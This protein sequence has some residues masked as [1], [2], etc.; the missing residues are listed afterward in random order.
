M[1]VC[2]AM[3]AVIC[4]GQI[5]G[6]T[7]LLIVIMALFL[8]VIALA[9]YFRLAFA[10]L[11]FFLPWSPL[12]KVGL[13]QISF[14]TIA[15]LSACL[16]Y[17]FMQG[18]SLRIFQIVLPAVIISLTLI[19]KALQSN[20]IANNYLCFAA[21]LVFFPCLTRDDSGSIDFWTLTVF[22]SVGIITA[23]FTAQQVVVYSNIAKYITVESYLK[24]TRLSG[25]YGDPNF[26]AA[27]ITACLAGV[28]L[29]LCYERDKTK[30]I[31]LT[32]LAVLLFYCGLLSASKMFIFT[33][34]L[35]FLIWIPALMKSQE[36]GSGRL[37]LIVG[38]LCA[39]AFILSSEAFRSLFRIIDNR[40]VYA[41]DISELTTGRTELWKRYFYELTHNPLLLLF[42]EGF[43]AATLNNKASHNTIIQSFFQFGI[44]G[45][46]FIAAWMYSELRSIIERHMH[47]K[48]KWEYILLI[49]AGVAFPWMSL[50]IMF[51]DEFFL[52]PAYAVFSVVF[53][54]GKSGR[55]RLPGER[56]LNTVGAK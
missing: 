45:V 1:A 53:V 40:F 15:L 42:G 19:G 48:P 18:F 8:L 44:T 52:L 41:S 46:P 34:A 10:V 56:G 22:F 51:F 11:L 36:Y 30:Q 7:M 43:S 37:R 55:F 5:Q 33:A 20:S 21:L 12:I 3:A 27:H 25:F 49:V 38:L 9:C 16:I 35:Q 17:C 31:V 29:L 6:S 50:D 32:L 13:G 54:S 39:G 47:M 4:F 2:L 23:A 26:Y 14:Y 24:I 28:Q